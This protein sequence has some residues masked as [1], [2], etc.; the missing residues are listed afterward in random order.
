M[1]EGKEEKY[2]DVHEEGKYVVEEVEDEK[3]GNV[4]D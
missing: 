1:E 4:Y 3:E 2:R